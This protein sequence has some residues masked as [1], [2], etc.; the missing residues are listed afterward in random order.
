[1]TGGQRTPILRWLGVVLR[2][3]HLAAIIGLGAA[4]L[5][6]PL[7]G[8]IQV[9]AVLF[10]GA[11]M[12]TLD[13]WVRPHLVWEWSGAAL[14]LKLLVVA[15]MAIDDGSRLCLFWLL[16]VWSAIFA[17][18]PSSFRHAPWRRPDSP[19]RSA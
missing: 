5:G 11:A 14:F 18:A 1:L 10:S 3:L 2:S 19:S 9:I 17:H 8:R 7:D 16:V 6:A 15:W 12:L 4:L 13:L